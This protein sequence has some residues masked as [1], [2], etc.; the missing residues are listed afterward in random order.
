[1]LTYQWHW[2]VFLLLV[3]FVWTSSFQAVE[4]I[5]PSRLAAETG[6]PAVQPMNI[7]PEQ[8]FDRVIVGVDWQAGAVQWRINETRLASAELLRAALDQ[9]HAVQP[10]APIVVQ[11][12]ENAPL[13]YVIQ[14]YDLAR[15]SGF[16]KV[17]LAAEMNSVFAP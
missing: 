17:S 9:I 2:F 16:N 13:A 7:S 4:S 8:D 11:P 5:L 1:M 10:Q 6:G 14:A 15:L 12:A 3:F